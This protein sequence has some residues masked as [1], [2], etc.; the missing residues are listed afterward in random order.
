MNANLFREDL[1]LDKRIK[2]M[3]TVVQRMVLR[4]RK[5]ATAIVA[6]YPISNAV[7]SGDDSTVK[8]TILRYMFPCKG[9][10]TRGCIKLGKKPK[11]GA[12]INA[13]VFGDYTS[14]SKGFT[15][16]RKTLFIEPGIEVL[17]G[18]CLEVSLE[19]LTEEDIIKEVWISFL[20]NP[21]IP[22]ASLKHFLIEDLEK[23]QDDFIEA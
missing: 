18:D 2:R 15:I 21:S 19:P 14:E 1:P 5:T 6:P 20:W 9:M 7:M 13:K 23:I 22:S 17:Q 8:G 12:I 11:N 4:S 10:I 16:E 3:E